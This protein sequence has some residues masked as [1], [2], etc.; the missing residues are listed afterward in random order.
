MPAGA[1]PNNCILGIPAGSDLVLL[2]PSR[3]ARTLRGLA[4]AANT[5]D[6]SI[7]R[8]VVWMAFHATLIGR[9]NRWLM[10][11][12]HSAFRMMM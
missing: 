10:S 12:R 2:P 9:L 6:L 7:D 3:L 8:D 5:S 4:P 1:R 11:D